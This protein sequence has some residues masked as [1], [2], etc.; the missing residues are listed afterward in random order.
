MDFWD[1]HHITGKTNDREKE[2]LVGSESGEDG[3]DERLRLS[4]DGIIEF[5]NKSSPSENKKD[6]LFPSKGL[7]NGASSCFV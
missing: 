2:R 7:Q 6:Q 1:V 4:G 3:I 5:L